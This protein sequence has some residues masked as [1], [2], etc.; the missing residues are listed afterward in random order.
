MAFSKIAAENLGGSTLP[1]LA[2]GSLTGISAGKIAQV[3]HTKN[4]T[5]TTVSNNTL[6]EMMNVAITPSATSSKIL[7]LC[8]AHIGKGTNN[9]SIIERMFRV[10]GGSDVATQVLNDI[11]GHTN[12]T[13]YN[14]IGFSASQFYDTPS[15]TSAI[16]YSYRIS[17]YENNAVVRFNNYHAGGSFSSQMTAMEILA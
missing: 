12:S 15:T 4:T 5:Y 1:A 6:V 2:G 9:T 14:E 13:A 16:T 11:S 7:V 17:S 10:V 3:T 8:S